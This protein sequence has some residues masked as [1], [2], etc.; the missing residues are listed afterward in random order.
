V[1]QPFGT[2]PAVRSDAAAIAALHAASWRCAYRGALSDEFLAGDIVADRMAVWS[3]RFRAAPPNQHVVVAESDKG[4]L[5]FACVFASADR[6]W[7]ALLDN[8]HVVRSSQRHGIG[9]R[10][11][12]E[13]ASW[14]V[15]RES[16]KGLFL[17]VLE[18][19]EGARRFYENLGAVNVGEDV[20]SPPG[21][22]AV[23]RRRYAWRDVTRLLNERR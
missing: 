3:E 14:C 1:P 6:E 16:D 4:L 13:I 20:W 5:G 8:L 17:W 12:R 9:S 22:G 10:L 15:T 11:V 18:A 21:G 19:N 7:G 23:T 2:R